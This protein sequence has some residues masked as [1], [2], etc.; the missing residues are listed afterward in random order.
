MREKNQVGIEKNKKLDELKRIR[1]K[2]E[3]NIRDI[4]DEIK[5][6]EKEE[7]INKL[8]EKIKR[9]EEIQYLIIMNDN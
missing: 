8:N 3:K 5:I 4:K 2:L 9:Y 6:K 7:L 1:E